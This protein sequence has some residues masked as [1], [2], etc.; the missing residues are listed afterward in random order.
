MRPNKLTDLNAVC[1]KRFVFR[2]ASNRSPIKLWLYYFEPRNIGKCTVLFLMRRTVNKNDWMN[3]KSVESALFLRNKWEWFNEYEICQIYYFFFFF[4]FF[5]NLTEKYPAS[6]CRFPPWLSGMPLRDL[7][8]NAIFQTD[9]SNNSMRILNI[10][11]GA[12]M[13]IRHS[14]HCETSLDLL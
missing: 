3:V 14:V 4:Y 10:T 2:R 11:T 6:Y 9:Q 13:Y 5:K 12:W 7:A 8:A 1:G